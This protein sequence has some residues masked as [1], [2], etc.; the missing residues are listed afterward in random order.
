[1]PAS[2]LQSLGARDSAMQNIPNPWPHEADIPV[3][4]TTNKQ[5]NVN[6]YLISCTVKMKIIKSGTVRECD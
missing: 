2:I 3:E 5:V 1:M 4:K 6:K